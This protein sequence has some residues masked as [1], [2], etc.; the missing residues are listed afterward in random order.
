[1]KKLKKNKTLTFLIILSIIA[2]I[3][4]VFFVT[5]ISNN[6]VILIKQYINTFFTNIFNNKIVFID[7]FKETLFM[8]MIFIF[9]IWLLGL[10]VIFLPIII[11]FY[12]FKVFS[13]GFALTSFILTYKTKGIVFSLLYLFPNEILKYFIYTLLTFNTIKISKK[14]FNSIIKKQNINFNNLIIKYLKILG[15]VIILI[16]ISS[17]YET[18]VIP[19]IFSKLHFLIK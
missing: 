3:F 10:L 14:I 13:L 7:S 1:M 4:G 6:D 2:F 19:F 8:N 18:Y 5:V 17:L 11:F 9:I 15:I 12:F 16:I